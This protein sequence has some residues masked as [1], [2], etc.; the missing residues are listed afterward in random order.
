MATYPNCGKLLEI[1]LPSNYWKHNYGRGNTPV[2]G[3]NAKY[4]TIRSQVPKFIYFLEKSM[5]KKYFLEKSMSKKYFLKKKYSKKILLKK[6]I[7]IWRRFR[8]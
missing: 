6:S 5:A 3:K 2:Y 8:D 7:K 1:L 4:W